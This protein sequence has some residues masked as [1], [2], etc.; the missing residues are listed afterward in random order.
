MPPAAAAIG[1]LD[2]VTDRL[3]L[4]PGEIIAFPVHQAVDQQGKS[5]PDYTMVV[6]LEGPSEA[7]YSFKWSMTEPL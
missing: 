3:K 4:R 2:D 6:E 5:K 1:N 7:A